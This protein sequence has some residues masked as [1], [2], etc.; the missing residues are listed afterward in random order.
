MNGV[1]ARTIHPAASRGNPWKRELLLV[2]ASADVRPEFQEE[3]AGDAPQQAGKATPDGVARIGR[4]PG[5][6]RW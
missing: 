1:G 3:V 4:C 5:A 6:R 2:E